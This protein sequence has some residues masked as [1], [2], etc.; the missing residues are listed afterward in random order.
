MCQNPPTVADQLRNR[1][2]WGNFVKAC[3][4]VDIERDQLVARREK[5]DRRLKE[6]AIKEDAVL[7]A[8]HS[9]ERSLLQRKHEYEF[10]A[11]RTDQKRELE[12]KERLRQSEIRRLEDKRDL[13]DKDSAESRKHTVRADRGF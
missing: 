2:R 5:E 8:K 10:A 7:D 13:E 12:A 6:D 1:R 3:E 4:V 9:D 11:L